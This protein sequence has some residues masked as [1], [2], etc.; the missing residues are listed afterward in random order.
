MAK[1]YPALTEELIAF[2]T[3]QK[4][5]FVATAPDEG[6]INLSPK[7][8]DTFRCF[9]ERSVG[10][11]DLTGSGNE[12]AAHTRQNG[13]MTVMFCSFDEKPMILRLYGQ[14]RVVLPGE[15]Q[16]ADV[17]PRFPTDTP[18][19]R[20]IMLLDVEGVQTS[21]GFAVPTAEAM[22][23]RPTLREWAER[24]GEDG[25]RAYWAEKNRKTIDG[26]PTPFED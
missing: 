24:K 14:G 17:A 6:R 12:T 18:G 8:M 5:F 26:L 3:R 11:L 19:T 13:R 23:E 9:D 4:V 21:C 22:Q 16:W 10:Y 1:F 20:Q 25:I 7:G 15:P 2:I